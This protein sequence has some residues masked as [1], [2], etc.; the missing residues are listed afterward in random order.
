MFI[1]VLVDDNDACAGC[2]VRYKAEDAPRPVKTVRWYGDDDRGIVCDVV[3]WSP[4]GPVP[5]LACTVEDS[6]AGTAILVWGGEHGLRLTPRD[7]GASFGES[8]LRL[9]PDDILE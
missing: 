3:G 6:G 8:H 7:G 2:A 1:E 4:Q 9:A 5:A